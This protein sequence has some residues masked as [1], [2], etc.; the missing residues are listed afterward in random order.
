MGRS[1]LQPPAGRSGKPAGVLA[2]VVETTERVRAEKAL[3]ESEA[4]FRTFA[5][6]MPNHVWS[7]TPDGKLDWFNQQV[8]EYTGAK[9]D[10]LQGDGWGEVVEPQ[11]LERAVAA[12]QKALRESSVYEVQ[13]RL[14]RRDGVYRWHLARA[15]PIRDGARQG[16]PLDRHQ[17]R[18]RR[19]D[20]RRARLA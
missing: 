18:H 5:A 1:R 7:A 9:P 8:F 19:P 2:V 13:F 15:M 3:R 11:D 20:Q 17:H 6:A 10:E 14:R 12:W 4:Q 16:R